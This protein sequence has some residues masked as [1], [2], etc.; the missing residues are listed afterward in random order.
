MAALWVLHDNGRTE[1]IDLALALA[2]DLDWGVLADREPAGGNIV[3]LAERDAA[4]RFLN[5]SADPRGDEVQAL[6]ADAR[7]AHRR[8]NRVGFKGEPDDKTVATLALAVPDLLALMAD[9][10]RFIEAELSQRDWPA[11]E[12]AD[13]AAFTDVFSHLYGNRMEA[14]HAG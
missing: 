3:S 6:L 11:L 14:T 13:L 9:S 7:H 10:R 1:A 4:R 12:V 8:I 5:E 2:P